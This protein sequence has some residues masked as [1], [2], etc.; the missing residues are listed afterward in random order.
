MMNS[1]ESSVEFTEL[2]RI[3]NS[4]KVKLLPYHT[5]IHPWILLEFTITHRITDYLYDKLFHLRLMIL[6]HM[7]YL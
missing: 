2:P 6:L 7:N 4:E 1:I 5:A 3:W